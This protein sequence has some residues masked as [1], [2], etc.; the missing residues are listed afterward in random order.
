[1]TRKAGLLGVK[2]TNPSCPTA[3]FLV[4]ISWTHLFAEFVARM[5]DVRLPK[6]VIFRELVG[7]RAA[8]GPNK[9][10]R[11]GV[12]WTTSEL[13]AST[14]T[15]RRL[16]PRTRGNSAGRWNKG[17]NVSCRNKSLQRKPGLDYGMQQFERDG[18]DQR[19]DTLKQAGSCWFAC[20]N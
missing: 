17:R 7:A 1:M 13:S 19:E 3:S 2:G 20:Y 10:S 6:C 11:G 5:E 9:N 18:K 16:Q 15:S 8:S 4:V 12:F 14:P